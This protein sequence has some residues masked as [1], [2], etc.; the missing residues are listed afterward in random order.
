MWCARLCS[1]LGMLS[2]LSLGTVT[3]AAAAPVEQTPFWHPPGVWHGPHYRRHLVITV[4][5][6]FVPPAPVVAPP[7]PAPPAPLVAVPV[8]V[9]ALQPI[10]LPAL[11]QVLPTA[12]FD[13]NPPNFLFLQGNTYALVHPLLF[14]GVDQAATCQVLA[15]QLAQ[16]TP[17]WGTT[18][19]DGPEGYG[20]YLTFQGNA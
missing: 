11:E 10:V 7:L 18:V 13:Q 20:V 4:P 6:P 12:G 1:I 2:V 9:P 8:P 5:A 19:M 3:G 15:Q 17:G 16:I 14:C